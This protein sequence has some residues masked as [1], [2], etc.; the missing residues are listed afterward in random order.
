MNLQAITQVAGKSPQREMK[1]PS[2]LTGIMKEERRSYST[3]GVQVTGQDEKLKSKQ[4]KGKSFFPL[5]LGFFP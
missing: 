5:N 2:R 3:G 4:A 1:W